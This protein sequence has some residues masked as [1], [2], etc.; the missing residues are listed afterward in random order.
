MRAVDL[1]LVVSMRLCG[2]PDQFH[3]R[4]KK[5][6]RRIDKKRQEFET[7]TTIGDLAGTCLVP[8]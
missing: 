6:T 1:V 8:Q 3:R 2:H 4:A 7:V 5:P